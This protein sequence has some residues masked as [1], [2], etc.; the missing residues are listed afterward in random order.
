MLQATNKALTSNDTFVTFDYTGVDGETV[1]YQLPSYNTVVNR[2]LAVEESINSLSTGKGSIN[3][4]DGTRRTIT[5]SSVPT[6]P[7]QITG[8]SD[9]STFTIDSNWFFEDLMFPKAGQIL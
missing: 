1:Q 2:L 8:I 4:S 5:L 9:P 6:T 7:A 3:L